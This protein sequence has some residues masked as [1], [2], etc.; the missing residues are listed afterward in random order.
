MCG[1]AGLW[2][3]GNIER[4]VRSLIH[5]G[6]DGTGFFHDR[7]VQLGTARLAILDLQNG[8]QPMTSEDGKKTIVHNGEV[9]NYIEIRELLRQ[10]GYRFK[11]ETDTEV[12][13][14]SYAEW[15]ADC[16]S[17]FNGMFAF[18]IWDADREE[19][20]LARDRVGVKPLFWAH[21]ANRFLFASEIKSILQ[22]Y[23]STPEVPETF[24]SFECPVFEKTLFHGIHSLLPGTFLRFDGRNVMTH[25]YWKIQENAAEE[26][27]SQ[28]EA[29][30]KLSWLVRDAVRLRMRSDTPIGLFLSG[31]IDSALLASLS[32]VKD[33][34]SCRYALGPNYDEFD[35]VRLLS[36]E[37]QLT[38][39]CVTPSAEDL[40]Q[41]LKEIIYFLDHPIAT[42]S[43][44]SEFML[45]KR[46]SKD[47]KVVLGGQGADEIFGGY[48]RYLVMLAQNFQGKQFEGYESLTSFFQQQPEDLSFDERYFFLTNRGRSNHNHKSFVSFFNSSR[49]RIDQMGL[50][51]MVFVLPSLLTMNDRAAAHVGI[52]NRTPYLDYRIVE[53]AFQLPQ[54]L[55]IQDGIS[56]FVLREVCKGLVPKQILQRTD[57]KGLVTPVSVWLNGPLRNWAIHLSEALTKRGLAQVYPK[58]R[59]EF[60]R[61]LYTRISLELWFQNFFPDF[62]V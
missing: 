28:A 1:I 44:L 23:P 3:K 45:A 17:R 9:Y 8:K 36:E 47:V 49:S 60:D 15:G 41:N 19:L 32:E 2:G 20:F 56:K 11:T 37:L 62:Q 5:R 46:A 4:M 16:L 55:K 50:C 39:V 22:E 51:D 43:T 52:E 42:A 24:Y 26:K 35:Y 27:I 25:Q 12:I 59:G 57:K 18:A 29:V 58:S 34:Y 61:Y 31:G 14:Y 30:E 53:F 54:Q 48:V 10:K 38:P 33:V 21:V 13:L 40:E 7:E 6:P